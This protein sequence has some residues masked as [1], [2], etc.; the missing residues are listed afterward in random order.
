MTEV[1]QSGRLLFYNTI[2]F[3][4]WT[5]L[6][7]ISFWHLQTHPAE[8]QSIVA[9]LDVLQQK[10]TVLT[11]KLTWYDRETAKEKNEYYRSLQE[12]Y[13]TAEQNECL[14]EENLSLLQETLQEIDK[15]SLQS[16]WQKKYEYMTI[17]LKLK[18]QMENAC[19]V[20]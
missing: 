13:K 11:Y 14:E 15:D 1:T 19:Q 20:Y 16:F 10:V 18:A 9:S 7:G 6:L 17:W 8:K 2:K 12:L 4:I 3:F 5:V